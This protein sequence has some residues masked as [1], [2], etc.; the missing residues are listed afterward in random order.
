MFTTIVVIV[1]V[2]ATIV[3]TLVALNFTGGDKNLK[4]ELEAAYGVKD[5]QFLNVM[6]Q[7]LGPPI[8]EGNSIDGHHNGDEIFPAL[9]TAIRSATRTICF[10]TY[11]YWSG[12]IGTE[13][14]EALCDRARAG[15]K[16]HVLLDWV[17]SDKINERLIDQMKTAGVEVER[18]RPPRWY[19]LS[20]MNN[21]THR[22]LLIVDGRIGF[23]GGVG[24]ADVWLG[25]A[26]SPDHWRDSHFQL[27]GPAVAQ[28]QAAFMDNWLKARS[29]VHHDE[30][31]FPP[32]VECGTSRASIPEFSHGW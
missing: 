15:V 3:L 13:F 27:E 21:R 28:L 9:L 1:T 17:G 7:L 24:I 12:R 2:F 19:N 26:D 31:Y 5:A 10:E 11:I 20:R 32:L 6:S 30:D 18:F 22:K 23:T 8:V 29:I 14:S 16:C 25:N 4:Y